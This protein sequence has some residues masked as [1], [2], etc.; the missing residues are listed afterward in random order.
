MARIRKAKSAD[1]AA[2]MD[3]LYDERDVT[4]GTGFYYNRSWIENSFDDGK[5]FVVDEGKTVVG[6]VT[7][8]EY[9]GPGI[10]GAAMCQP[11]S[12]DHLLG[13]GD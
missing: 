6:F 4:M 5:M 9:H 12:F 10:V 8:D 11:T 13:G 1:M 3:W 7:A 2:V